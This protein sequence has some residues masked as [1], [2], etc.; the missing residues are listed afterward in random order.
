MQQASAKSLRAEFL[1]PLARLLPLRSEQ[2][3]VY[4]FAEKMPPG[5]N[6][7]QP[8]WEVINAVLGAQK[9]VQVKVDLMTDFHLMAALAQSSANT[10]GGFRL[11][12][13]DVR[14]QRAFQDRPWQ[15]S[16]FGGA[17]SIISGM[18]LREP[19]RFD[20]PKSQLLCV[21]QSLEPAPITVQIALYGA[22]APFTGSLSNEHC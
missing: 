10:V 11:Q 13:Y 2:E 5:L 9:T 22:S 18:F 16:Q 4:R 20:L 19:Y 8:R 15:F 1:N 3:A 21:L 17:A 14:K 6:G 7:Y 12:L